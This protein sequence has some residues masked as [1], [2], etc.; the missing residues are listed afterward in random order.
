MSFAEGRQRIAIQGLEIQAAIGLLDWEKQEKQR[1]RIDVAVYRDNFG[2]ES[3][4]EDCY[5]S[6]SY[7]HLTLPTSD[8]V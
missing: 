6:V 7:T 8:L 4:L 2:Q 3:T 5:D 1:L